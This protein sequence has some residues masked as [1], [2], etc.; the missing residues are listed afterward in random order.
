M[1][2]KICNT[3]DIHKPIT[4]YR[5]N[6]KQCKSCENKGRYQRNKSR[7]KND[8]IYNELWKKYDVLRKRKKERENPHVMFI[9]IT[10]QIVRRGIKRCGYTKKS[11]TYEILGCTY[12]EFKLHLESKFEYWMNWDNHGK[13]NGEKNYGWDLDHIIPLSSVKTEEDII[14]LNHYTN[15][16]PLCSYVNRVIK[17]DKIK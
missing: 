8:P 16:Q 6:R 1:E 15:I 3:C 2:N 10:R 5:G 14:R 13:Y 7:K 4:E 17:K 9:Q 11:K 12:D